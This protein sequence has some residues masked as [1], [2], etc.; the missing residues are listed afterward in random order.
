GAEVKTTGDGLMLRFDSAASA[1]ACAV[2]MQQG[3]QITQMDADQRSSA[4][5]AASIR[6]G[7]SSGEA[8]H[9][10]GDLFG[11]PVVE[12]AR[13]CAV[14][15]GGQ[16]VVS[17]VVRTL[18]RGRGH[19]FT[20]LGELELKGLP[21]PVAACEVQWEPSAPIGLPLPPR[22]TTA[23]L[24]MFGRATET[25]ALAAARAKTKDGQRQL[26][27]VAGEPGIGKTRL[28]TEA[29]LTAHAEGAVVLLGTCDEDVNL[30][31][32]PFV[33][34]VRHYVT[35]APDDV[36]AAHV[37]E[38]K[39]ELVRLAPELAKRVADLPAPQVA[40]AETERYLLFEAATGLLSE[41]SK[42]QPI[43]LILDD[44]HWAGAPEL[45]LLKHVLK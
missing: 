11:P 27:L 14:A 30:P 4:K 38:H 45:L 39:G 41:A 35:H 32:Q 21:E 18:A 26:V 34:A 24:G 6:I 10:D 1:I 7:V 20:P 23:T 44:L 33:E 13:L 22:L 3:P 29:A 43:V 9:E 15:T 8:T 25:A 42:A 16:I 17:D 31:Y 40:E 2:A 37:R 5:S 28:A 19:V 12:A 36:L